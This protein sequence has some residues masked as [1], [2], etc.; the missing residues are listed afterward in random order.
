LFNQHQ[1]IIHFHV[2]RTDTE[3]ANAKRTRHQFDTILPRVHTT[4]LRT[5]TPLPELQKSCDSLRSQHHEARVIEP[6]VHSFA[7]ISKSK[8]H[9][10]STITKLP[11]VNVAR[12]LKTARHD[13]VLIEPAVHTP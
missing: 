4:T 1:W 6:P 11:R 12:T 7:V 10:P 8:S 9:N 2:Y 5:N 13:S 3:T